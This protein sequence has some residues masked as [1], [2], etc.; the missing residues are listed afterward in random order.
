MS[1]S[2]PVLPLE[3]L[4]SSPTA[5]RFEGAGGELGA[6]ADVSF[7]LVHT[8]PGGG[9]GLHTHPYAEVFVLQAGTAEYVV[10]DETVRVEAGHVLVV[11]PDTPH[12]YTNVG[13]EPLLQ[14][15]VHDAGTMVQVELE[16][17]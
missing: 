12:R 10:G 17:P 1:T 6:P 3:A 7:F 2:P 9:P 13:D 15:S 14:F 8:P 11:P 16:A 4:R 5:Y